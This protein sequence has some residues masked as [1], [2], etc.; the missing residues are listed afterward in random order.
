MRQYLIGLV[1]AWTGACIAATLYTQQQGIPQRIAIA[2]VP[3]FL[4]EIA[5]YL[6]AG[7]P[8][9][10]KL[11]DHVV[12]K[13][14]RAALLT[15]SAIAPY[16]LLSVRLGSFRWTSF[17]LLT[18]ASGAVAFWYVWLRPVPAV[19]LLFLVLMAGVFMSKIF[20]AIYTRPVAHLPLDVLGRLM[21]IRMGILA[22]LSMRRMQNVQIGFIPSSV[23]WRIGIQYF[24]YF[25]PLAA[26][27][28]YFL[29]IVHFHPIARVWWKIPLY[30][31]GTF[32][33]VLWVLALAEEFFFRGFL[34]QLLARMLHS[35]IAG[36]IVASVV[37]GMAHISFRHFPNWPF[38]ALAALAGLFYGLA[39]MRARSVR[40]CMVTHALVVTTWRVFFPN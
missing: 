11:V 22:V 29:H 30:T 37:F 20:P 34:Q 14:A 5:L 39:Y 25:V 24:L 4:L 40:A 38:A 26:L 27:A 32:L 10:R 18:A 6:G 21:W 16:L 9:T 1:L 33:G 13:T 36:L 35:E 8:Q 17:A 19:D 2:V 15:A 31:L 7:F 12:A 3:A 23:E 28:A